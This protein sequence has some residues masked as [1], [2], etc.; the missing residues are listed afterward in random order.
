[1]DALYAFFIT[2]F[3]LKG[4]KGYGQDSSKRKRN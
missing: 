1:M 4:G 3:V 2:S